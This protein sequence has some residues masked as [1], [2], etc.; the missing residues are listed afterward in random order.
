[1]LAYIPGLIL[2]GAGVYILMFYFRT[3]V[4][5]SHKCVYQFGY[6]ADWLHV[7]NW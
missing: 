6:V 3:R 2:G 5:L 7:T 1:M 4:Q